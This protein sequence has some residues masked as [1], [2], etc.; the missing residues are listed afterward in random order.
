LRFSILLLLIL[1]P[2][3]L[4]A[5]GIDTTFR[6]QYKDNRPEIF[7]T[8][9]KIVQSVIKFKEMFTGKIIN[10]PKADIEYIKTPNGYIFFEEKIYRLDYATNKMVRFFLFGGAN[11]FGN[12]VTEGNTYRP[13]ISG[14]GSMEIDLSL[15]QNRELMKTFDFKV[16]LGAEYQFANSITN[17]PGKF[18]FISFFGTTSLCFLNEEPICPKLFARYGTNILHGSADYPGNENFS[19]SFYLSAGLGVFFAHRFE[20]RAAYTMNKAYVERNQVKSPI[21]YRTLDLNLGVQ[22]E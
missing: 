16:G 5:Q 6:V 21:N 11:F 7:G 1:F 20:I 9:M 22:I 2:V 4:S 19:G 15:L 3:I 18:N 14:S 12:Y 8:D 10:I 13:K 17:I